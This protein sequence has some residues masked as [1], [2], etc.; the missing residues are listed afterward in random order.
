MFIFK[1]FLP[2]NKE[3]AHPCLNYRARY[4]KTDI[5]MI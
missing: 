2:E 4:C 5:F 3:T 1:T